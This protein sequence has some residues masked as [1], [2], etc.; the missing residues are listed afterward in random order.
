MRKFNI[1]DEVVINEN[2]QRDLP[3]SVGKHGYIAAFVEDSPNF[4]YRVDIGIVIEK[5]K[6]REIDRITDF[7]VELAKVGDRVL[8]TNTHEFATVTQIDEK[9]NQ[10]SIKFKDGG[11]KLA[12]EDQLK[13]IINEEN[14]QVEESI[15]EVSEVGKFEAIATSLGRFTDEKNRQYGSSV[16]AT[17]EMMKA[18]MERYT[19]DE[20]NYLMPKNL[21]QH[22]LLQVRMM[23]KQNRI[24]NNPSGKGDSESPY[25][26]LTGY[27]LIG[28][29]MV[30]RN[31][32]SV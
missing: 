30:E 25:K 31:K 18:L 9:Y 3:N 13:L 2:A 29:E 22:I 1:E 10:V 5:V 15:E 4:D 14:E 11:V 6:E 21:L 7:K 8:Y 19:Y 27:S 12:V 20:E 16:D 26:D 24:F 32:E 28:V 23:D 17:L